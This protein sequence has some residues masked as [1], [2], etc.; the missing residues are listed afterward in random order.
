M[1]ACDSIAP[2]DRFRARLLVGLRAR[3][4]QLRLSC[5]A[6]DR[7]GLVPGLLFMF[8][9]VAQLIDMTGY[10][11]HRKQADWLGVNGYSFDVR[12]DGRPNVL[13]AQV[14]ERQC[15][16]EVPKSKPDLAALDRLS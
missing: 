9:S 16:G 12:A 7:P 3:L 4:C 11:A 8:L 14:I 2:T 13:H 5:K 10:R 1:P 15:K 6:T